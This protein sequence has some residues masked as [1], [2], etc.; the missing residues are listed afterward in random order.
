MTDPRPA[1]GWATRLPPTPVA[2]LLGGPSAEHD[3]SVV[4]GLAVARALAERGHPVRGWL[5]GLD[6]TWW[7]LPRRVLDDPPHATA[8][9]APARLGAS[10]PMSAAGA[11]DELARGAP[12][13]VV[14]PALHGPFGEDGTVQA[15]V[16]SAGLVCCGSGVAA[17]AVGMDKSLFKRLCRTLGL[18]VL[19]W[20]DIDAAAWLDRRPDTLARLEAFASGLADPRLVIKPARLGS[21]IGISIVGRPDEPPELEHAVEEALRY[22]D[23][24]LAEPYLDH[25]REL[26]V[27]LVGDPATDI[28]VFGP[29]EVLPGRT[30]YDYE[31]KYRSDASRTLVTP[32]LDSGL[33]TEI[34]R[35]ARESF[36]VIGASG[37]ARVDFLV[38]R[39][40]TP[41][42]SEINTIPGF[43]PISL[44][45]MLV[46]AAGHDFGAVCE[47]IVGLALERVAMSPMRRLTRGDL[48]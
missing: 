8:F 27:A 5:I 19:P 11:L 12:A 15:L 1:T 18:P 13:P 39:D 31:A 7:E 46:A 22:G 17:S 16:G 44:F 14:F 40:G 45:P 47:R 26:E 23:L 35:I 48:P 25:P 34:R 37:F 30:F 36:L 9:D 3:V 6:G 10:G 2:V 28:E 24:A 21:S 38:E 29:G 4:S 42:L 41:W 33:A 32:D 20:Q 43:T